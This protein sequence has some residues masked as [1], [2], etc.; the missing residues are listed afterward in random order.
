MRCHGQWLTHDADLR[1]A[2]LSWADLRGADLRGA[3]LS[4]A[5]LYWADLH[6]ADLLGA[7]LVVLQLP[8]WTAYVQQT[9]TRI[10]C[11]YHRNDEW[12]AFSDE[13]INAMDDEAL[14]WWKQHKRLVF[15][16]MDVVEGGRDE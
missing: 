16:A 13:Q 10:A 2:D 9:H 12:R 8:P 15:A 1:R 7:G 4:R 14:K 3:N 11:Q 6:C 5:N